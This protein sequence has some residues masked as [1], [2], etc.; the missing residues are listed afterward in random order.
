MLLQLQ[1]NI[2]KIDLDFDV[3]KVMHLFSDHHLCTMP[4]HYLTIFGWKLH[5][6]NKI[7]IIVCCGLTKTNECLPVQS[8]KPAYNSYH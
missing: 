7:I 3:Y 5:C 4:C 2:L 1:S 8:S 6:T